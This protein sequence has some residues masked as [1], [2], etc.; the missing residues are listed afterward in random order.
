M[1]N[2]SGEEYSK[3]MFLSTKD[4]VSPG[5]RVVKKLKY[6]FNKDCSTKYENPEARPIKT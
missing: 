2:A 1:K 5:S 6:G 4:K 3:K